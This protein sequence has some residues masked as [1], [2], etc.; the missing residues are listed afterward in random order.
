M[1]M[2]RRKILSHMVEP[3]MLFQIAALLIASLFWIGVFYFVHYE[4][5][6]AEKLAIQ[7]THE[8]A[9][10]YESRMVRNLGYIDQTLKVVKFAYEHHGGAWCWTSSTER[11][12]CRPGWFLR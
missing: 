4:Q 1:K 12:C 2:G 11:K 7:K 6:A 9:D 5:Q 10:V 8:L 3:H